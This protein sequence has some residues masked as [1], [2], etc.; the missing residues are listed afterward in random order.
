MLTGFVSLWCDPLASLMASTPV[1]PLPQNGSRTMSPGRDRI[2]IRK[3][4]ICGI[5]FPG[6]QCNVCTLIGGVADR[7]KFQSTRFNARTASADE[8]RFKQF[9]RV[10]GARPHHCEKCA[11]HL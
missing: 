7:G 9:E 2:S 8:M 1:V 4:G 10:L 3:R 5:K 6:N 11:E